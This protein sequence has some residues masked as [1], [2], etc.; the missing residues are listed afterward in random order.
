MTPAEEMTQRYVTFLRHERGLAENSIAIYAP[1]ARD[2]FTY[3]V[4]HVGRLAL[5]TLDADTVRT[6]L[7]ARIANRSTESSRL[8]S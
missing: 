4:T 3:C 8:R 6:F 1:C 5:K 7:L 2:F